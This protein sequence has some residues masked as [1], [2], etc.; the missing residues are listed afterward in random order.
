[1]DLNQILT[2]NLLV[3]STMTILRISL[4][5]PLQRGIGYWLEPILALA[6]F[7]KTPL[8]LV[9]TGVTN[10]QLVGVVLNVVNLAD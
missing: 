2:E 6:P 9:L 10:N 8:H 3:L 5:P 4:T 1:M 7:C